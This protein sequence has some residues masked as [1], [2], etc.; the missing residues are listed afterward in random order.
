MSV[1]TSQRTATS[2]TESV[3]LGETEDIFPGGKFAWT[4]WK[5]PLN[6]YLYKPVL[7]SHCWPSQGLVMCSGARAM[8]Q[9][10]IVPCELR[11]SNYAGKFSYLT[12]W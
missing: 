10:V 2:A 8:A 5:F 11:V 4:C 3:L 12:Q 6:E 9:H 7:G 1:L